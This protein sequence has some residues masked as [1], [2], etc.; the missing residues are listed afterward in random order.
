MNGIL[1]CY[2]YF[3]N[4]FWT[5]DQSACQEYTQMLQ[6]SP[7][8]WYVVSGAALDGQQASMDRTV[9]D[10]LSA[11]Y[12]MVAQTENSLYLFRLR[13]DADALSAGNAY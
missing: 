5:Y 11:R 3:S 1:P 6:D 10:T 8:A 12:E 4:D 7:P 9:T 2:K 13:D